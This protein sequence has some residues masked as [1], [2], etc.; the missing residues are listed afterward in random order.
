MSK[1]LLPEVV[2]IYI[3]HFRISRKFQIDQDFRSCS[4]T[5]SDH[6]V[7]RFEMKI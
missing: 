3:L 7:I 4:E 6:S 2:S 5:K 1:K